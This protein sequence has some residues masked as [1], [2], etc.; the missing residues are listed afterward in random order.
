MGPRRFFLLLVPL[1]LVSCDPFYL[2]AKVAAVCQQLPAQ[3]FAVPDELRVQLE[4]VPVEQRR[5]QL[6]RT[7]DLQ[8]SFQLPE[9][10]NSL[11]KSRFVLSSVR[12][13]SVEGSAP[14]SFLDEA[15]VT[16]L[17]PEASG[18]PPQHF[19]YVRTEVEPSSISWKVDAFDLSPYLEA[20]GLQYQV[21]VAGLLPEQDLVVD[22]QVCATATLRF[23]YL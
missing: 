13:T 3:R 14:L 12:L 2:E 17:P 22:V 11:L 7:F 1:S 18:L 10:F 6:E 21:S 20:E 5:V 4:L 23:D 16:V 8:L 15:H 9:E 19:D